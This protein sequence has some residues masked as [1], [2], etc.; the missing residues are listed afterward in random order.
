[1]SKATK[2]ARAGEKHAHTNGSTGESISAVCSGCGREFMSANMRL[3]GGDSTKLL[4]PACT[5]L[6]K[7]VNFW[8]L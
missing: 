8:D 7:H 5:R 3:K 2:I 1:M 6:L 4:C